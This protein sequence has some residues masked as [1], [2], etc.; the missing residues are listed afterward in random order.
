[1]VKC[2]YLQTK[3]EHEESVKYHWLCEHKNV[4][5]KF[6]NPFYPNNIH[7]SPHAELQ[8]LIMDVF[9]NDFKWKNGYLLKCL[10]NYKQSGLRTEAILWLL[11]V[12]GLWTQN[13]YHES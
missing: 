1:M 11:R 5:L 9:L 2:S 6:F 8:S 3:V 12:N 4:L 7:Q 10:E 13:S